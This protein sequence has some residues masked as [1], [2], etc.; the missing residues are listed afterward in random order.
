MQI[1]F[2][3]PKIQR[4]IRMLYWFCQEI[5][6]LDHLLM[7]GVGFDDLLK[8][9]DDFLS[10]ENKFRTSHVRMNPEREGVK[11]RLFIL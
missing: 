1:G 4:E 3:I 10:E 5:E 7:L 2:P 11:I 8:T 9:S 6:N